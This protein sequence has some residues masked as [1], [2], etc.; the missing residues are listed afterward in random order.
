MRLALALVAAAALLACRLASGAWAAPRGAIPP[1][2]AVEA[3]KAHFAAGSAYYEQ[4]N[5]ADAAKEFKE[6]YRL[7]RRADLL[8][9]ISLCEERLGNLEGA[10]AALRSYLDVGPVD[11]AAI[12]ARIERLEQKRREATTTT[13]PPEPAP[14]A[15]AVS[16]ATTAATATVPPT[17]AR[18][19]RWWLPGTVVGAIGA[20]ALVAAL[21]TGISALRT[22]D[23]LEHFCV[24]KICPPDQRARVSRGEALAISTDVLIG[25]GVAAVITSAILIGVGA[26]RRPSSAVH[27]HNTVGASGGLAVQF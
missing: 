24:D 6:A 16:E 2:D 5:W 20:A 21:G 26:R 17:S 15:V 10:I 12:E 3:A 13:R 25:V 8:Y 19:P 23:E 11:R 1:S 4:G 7:S 27:A 9:N 14:A 18:A 22:A